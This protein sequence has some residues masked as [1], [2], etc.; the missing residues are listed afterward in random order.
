MKSSSTA[1]LYGSLAHLSRE[2]FLN[3]SGTWLRDTNLS[4]SQ[5]SSMHLR[6]RKSVTPFHMMVTGY[7]IAFIWMYNG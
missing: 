3:C 6:G 7:V 1:P 4:V 5:H 2:L